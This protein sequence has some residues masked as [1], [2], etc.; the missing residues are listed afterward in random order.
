MRAGHVA[1][2]AGPDRQVRTAVV[3]A[4]GVDDPAGRDRHRD[5]HLAVAAGIPE[6]LSRVRIVGVDARV[7]V[8]DELM[9]LAATDQ[10]RRRVRA[11]AL[12]ALGLPDLLARAAV[13]GQQV[14]RRIVVAL[15]D[16]EV[17]IDERR[18][19]VPPEHLEGGVLAR[20][21]PL[22]DR[23]AVERHRQELARPEPA[24]EPL[25]VGHRA[26]RREVVE[27]VDRRQRRL[28]LHALLP[29]DLPVGPAKALDHE[30]H[31]TVVLRDRPL[32]A[33]RGR[34]DDSVSNL[35]RDEDPV[36]EHDRRRHPA[37]REPRL[38][39]DV[40]R[41]APPQRKPRLGRDP[42]CLRAAPLGPVLGKRRGEGGE[43]G[44]SC[45]REQRRAHDSNIYHRMPAIIDPDIVRAKTMRTRLFL[46]VALTA[47]LA[48][49]QRAHAGD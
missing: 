48:S 27:H 42:V 29:L 1:A 4:T 47:G 14:S 16:E 11:Q 30:G 19:A 35:R 31:R 8:D 46:L 38:P 23:P 12:A 5:R 43:Q 28:G 6:V 15:E 24:V 40:L 32:V 36:P 22:P 25:A 41:R 18:A 3:A 21:A 37:P 44:A 49:A 20:E 26:R 17:L 9:A 7:R 2:P 33:R 34:I 45:D 10:E 13:Q 39:G